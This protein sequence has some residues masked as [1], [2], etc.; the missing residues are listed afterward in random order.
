M[1][2]H[3][4]AS[5][6]A[7]AFVYDFIAGSRSTWV[8]RLA[9][10][11]DI[12]A[13]AL[14]HGDRTVH[15]DLY[16]I[17]ARDSRPRPL[18]IV[19]HGFTHEG[20]TDPRLQELCRKLARQGVI[21]AAPQFDDMRRYRLGW[22]DLA[23]LETVVDTLRRRPDVDPSRIGVMAFSFGAAPALIG[24]SRPPL[25]DQVAFAVI[26]GGYFDLRRT[27]RYVL[28]GAYDG[29]GFSGW[30][31]PPAT[32]DDRWKFLMG[33]LGMI[34]SSSTSARFAD[35]V[36]ARVADPAAQVDLSGCSEEERAVWALIENRDPLQFDALYARAGSYIHDW[37]RRM[38]PVE[39]AAQIRAQLFLIHSYTDQKTPF[40]ESIAMSRSVPNAPPPALT[41]LNTFAHVDLV[42]DWRSLRSLLRDGLPG[43]LA[44]W[45]A[46][47]D[48]LMTAHAEPRETSAP[49]PFVPAR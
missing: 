34:P 18:L 30:N 37:I 10:P 29:C 11:V 45:R 12:S 35:A 17:A 16:R 49:A 1:R 5:I 15:C 24:L 26:F 41:L 43:L 46:V 48:I 27:F 7:L 22:Q 36:A 47:R 21:I 8:S 2:N 44:V 39:T 42:L 25:R 33:N 32:G 28:T 23:T 9:G 31:A 4:S 20:H 14:T 3:L 38:S 40:I 6:R 13:L 19:T